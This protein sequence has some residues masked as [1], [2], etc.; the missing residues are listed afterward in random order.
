MKYES[1]QPGIDPILAKGTHAGFSW[2]IC[3]SDHGTRLGYVLIPTDHVWFGKD[4]YELDHV[5]VHGG[6]TWSGPFENR[7]VDG[8]WV[9]FDTGHGL[10]LPDLTLPMPPALREILETTVEIKKR[11]VFPMAVRD[12]AF[13]QRECELLCEQARDVLP[14]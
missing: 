1:E 9:G 14:G 7:N 12:Q 4:T 6:I 5:F 8:W 2:M 13:V 3:C 11:S 10:D